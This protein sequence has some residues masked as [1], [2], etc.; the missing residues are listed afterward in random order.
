MPKLTRAFR[1]R[2]RVLD[3][4]WNPLTPWFISVSYGGQLYGR[5]YTNHPKIV[6]N[7]IETGV[8]SMPFG[9]TFNPSPSP[10]LVPIH[11]ETTLLTLNAVGG[12]GDVGE[13]NPTGVGQINPSPVPVPSPS[14][15]TVNASNLLQVNDTPL[16]V[17]A[18][19]AALASTS[20]LVKRVT[21]LADV[22]NAANIWISGG[23]QQ[24][25]GVG[26]PLNAGAAKDIGDI[27]SGKLVDLSTIFLTG[28]VAGDKVYLDIEA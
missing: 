15:S 4:V 7:T 25:A 10:P 3:R 17:G 5:T 23:V 26:F 12:F 16:I 6:V 27:S 11:G 24:A 19:W 1:Q 28:T 14:P 8:S 2:E 13:P 20:R 21:I 22:G 9:V 18:G